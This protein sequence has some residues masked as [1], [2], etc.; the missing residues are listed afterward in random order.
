MKF[1]RREWKE[2]MNKLLISSSVHLL[3]IAEPA[4]K[5]QTERYEILWENSFR[6]IRVPLAH[7]LLGKLRAKQAHRE[8][9]Y[10]PS[11]RTINRE[12]RAMSGKFSFFFFSFLLIQFDAFCV[13]ISRKWHENWKYERIPYTN[14]VR[15]KCTIHS[16]IHSLAHTNQ[17]QQCTQKK[18]RENK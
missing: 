9:L 2:A 13:F 12:W 4:K 15:P 10:L 5:Y 8:K 7:K 18:W 16:L 17:Q 6:I 3:S 1:L 11:I 14:H